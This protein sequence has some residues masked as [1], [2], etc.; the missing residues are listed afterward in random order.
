MDIQALF[1]Q[2]IG[3]IFLEEDLK[4]ITDYCFNL[5]E[6]RKLSNV[7]GFQSKDLDYKKNKLI[8]NLVTKI[9]KHINDYSKILSLKHELKVDNIWANINNYKDLNLEHIHAG[10]IVSGCFYIKVPENSGRIIFHSENKFFI[11]SENIVEQNQCNSM[12]WAYPPK[13]NLL[14]LFPSWLKHHVEPNM[15]NG[16][17]ISMSFNTYYNF[18]K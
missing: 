7:G 1:F 15:S 13:E 10:S 9:N 12:S 6:S 17:R 3:I 11:N 4:K 18:K 14:L 16:S 5:K 8:N 2:P